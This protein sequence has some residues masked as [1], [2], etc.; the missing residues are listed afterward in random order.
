[1]GG[2]EG[3]EEE[4]LGLSL[5]SLGSCWVGSLVVVLSSPPHVSALSSRHII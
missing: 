3:V 1:M 5:G 2:G 4:G